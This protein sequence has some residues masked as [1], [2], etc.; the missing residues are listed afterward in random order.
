MRLH[1][2]LGRG[3]EARERGGRADRAL[4]EVAAAVGAGPI[5][6]RLGAVRAEGAL[7]GAD[8]RIGAVRGEVPVAAFAIGSKGEHGLR[9]APASAVR[10][11][12]LASFSATQGPARTAGP[13][14]P[15]ISAIIRTGPSATS[16]SRPSAS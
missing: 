1:D 2:P 7:E 6:A 11:D 5:E 12:S 4:H 15:S 13:F 8:A 10:K 16:I 9:L 3:R 14:A